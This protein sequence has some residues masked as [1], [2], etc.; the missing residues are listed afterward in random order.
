MNRNKCCVI[1]LGY[2]G[3]PTAIVAAR[4]GF[5]LV[6][7][8][9]NKEI[10]DNLNKG[11]IQISEPKLESE[12]RK[13]INQ[14]KFKAQY[15]PCNADIFIIAVPTPFKEKSNQIPSPDI[16]FVLNAIESII[17]F[18]QK[19][20]LII[21][22]S[23]SPLGTTE[24]IALK[25]LK[26]TSLN[27]KQLKIAYCPERVLPGKILQEIIENDR[28]IGGINESSSK[29]AE[30]F[31]LN[32]CT[33]K[34]HLTNAKTAELIK[35]SENTFRDI[36]IAF[37]NELSIICAKEA[38][39]V[40]EVIK[41][42]NNHP[43]VN[44]LNPGIGVGGHCIAVDP[45][46]I[47]SKYP[48]ESKLI[49]TA[50]E[51]NNNKTKWVTS[52]IKFSALYFEEKFNKKPLIGF[53][54]LTFKPNVNDIRESSAL[55]IINQ[56]AIEKFNII[57]CEPNLNQVENIK[58]NSISYLLKNCDI[59][60]FLVAHKEFRNIDIDNEFVLD[61]CNAKGVNL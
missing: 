31:Y 32:F 53:F 43:R 57:C 30:S 45:W 59:F 5:D 37:A 40:N 42:A 49:K 26:E 2:I 60:V 55:K 8:D 19:N 17:P 54:G 7:V 52:K 12:L 4:A 36:N 21:L 25:I 46:F 47:A 48:K 23:T 11:V 10:V 3:I 15:K 39:D 61:F 29:A 34:I 35:L 51:V 9:K 50:R 33:G 41:I 16:S 18:I 56:L 22:E 24:K 28:V 38:I 58:L 6:G 1:G 13:I 20:N 27:E 14:K 44:I